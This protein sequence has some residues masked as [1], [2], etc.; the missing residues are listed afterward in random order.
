MV[1]LKDAITATRPDPRSARPSRLA[2]ASSRR[3]HRHCS[4]TSRL[5]AARR[6]VAT[7]ARDGARQQAKKQCAHHDGQSCS[8][9]SASRTVARVLACRLPGA[10]SA[11]VFRSEWNSLPV[12]WSPGAFDG[13]FRPFG[14][15]CT[16]QSTFIRPGASRP[17]I[18]VGRSDDRDRQLTAQ[19]TPL[20][21]HAQCRISRP[22][23][24]NATPSATASGSLR[25]SRL[26]RHRR[27]VDLGE[28]D[29]SCE[30]DCG[31]GP[32]RTMP[33]E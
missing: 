27:P 6:G 5:A 33:G 14:P 9:V 3:C 21:R 12:R 1:R 7:Q 8:G 28:K 23:A 2:A 15:N 32:A 29:G 19:P 4:S 22:T 17:T 18:G 25:A 13:S 30:S 10:R 24:A 20:L 31:T 16:Y 11:A 26:R